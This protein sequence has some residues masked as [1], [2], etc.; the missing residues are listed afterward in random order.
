[1]FVTTVATE[2]ETREEEHIGDPGFTA[3]ETWLHGR[4]GVKGTT[5]WSCRCRT[6]DRDA[7]LEKGIAYGV[8]VQMS[9]GLA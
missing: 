8:T 5:S 6:Y 1:M 9:S 2:Q 7:E 3:K 4:G